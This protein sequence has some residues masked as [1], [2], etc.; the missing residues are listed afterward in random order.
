MGSVAV[1][2]R[3]QAA[4]CYVGNLASKV[5]EE[6]LWELFTQC[7]PVE[8]VFMPKDKVTGAHYGYGFVEFRVTSDADYAARVMNFVKLFGSPLRV[9]KSLQDRKVMDVGANVF[10]GNLDPMVDEKLLFD[11]FSSF[12]KI[13]R[14]PTI[15]RDSETGTSRGIGFVHFDS[16]EASDMAIQCMNGQFLCNQQVSVEYALKERS[17]TERHGSAAERTLAAQ[18]KEKQERERASTMPRR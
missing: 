4:T 10:I 17:K 18:M 11:T 15:R 3:N 13:I 9:N 2:Q 16:F 6:L 8:H 7:G 1:E 14:S 5:S 12:G